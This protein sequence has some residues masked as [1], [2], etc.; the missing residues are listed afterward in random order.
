MAVQDNAPLIS[1]L[2]IASVGNTL[3]ALTT[4]ALGILVSTKYPVKERLS[5]AHQRGVGLLE[6]WGGAILVLSWLPVIGDAL[7]F[8]AGWLRFS[9]LLSFVAITLGKILRY[10]VIIYLAVY[11][12]G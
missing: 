9:F 8:A 10:A 5:T 11:V 1:L 6:K 12:A 4:F 2:F 7:C 3:G